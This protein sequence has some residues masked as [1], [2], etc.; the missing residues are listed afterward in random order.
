MHPIDMMAPTS[1]ESFVTLKNARQWAPL[2]YLPDASSLALEILTMA[3]NAY[4]NKKSFMRLANDACKLV[5][6]FA[7]VCRPYHENSQELPEWLI[8]CL[9]DIVSTLSDLRALVQSNVKRNIF[10]RFVKRIGFGRSDLKKISDHRDRLD[11]N[12]DHFK[13]EV[14]EDTRRKIAALEA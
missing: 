9:E 12:R 8:P 13:S 5:E 2:P 3:E 11:E 10:K 14:D 4:G 1:D 6:S 7:D